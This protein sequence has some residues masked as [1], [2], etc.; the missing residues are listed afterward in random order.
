MHKHV[1]FTHSNGKEEKKWKH[2]EAIVSLRIHFNLLGRHC[3][4]KASWYEDITTLG[5]NDGVNAG[6]SDP[7]R[8]H[9][10]S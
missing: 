10:I 7:Y 5:E 6:S 4:V 1:Q 3:Q 9:D 8:R 2:G